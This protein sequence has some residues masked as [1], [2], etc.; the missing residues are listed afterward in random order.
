MFYAPLPITNYQL[1]I[2][3]YQLP[4]TNYQKS[5]E[6]TAIYSYRVDKA[7]LCLEEKVF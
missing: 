4:I 3:N 2:T 6:V 7:V 5:A 1:P